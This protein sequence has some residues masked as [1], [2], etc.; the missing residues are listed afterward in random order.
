MWALESFTN[1]VCLFVEGPLSVI[2]LSLQNAGS[3][4]LAQRVESPMLCNVVNPQSRA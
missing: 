3:I 2:T 1:F 4:E